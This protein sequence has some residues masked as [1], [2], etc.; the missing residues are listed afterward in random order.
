MNYDFEKFF[1][2]SLDL[3][4]IQ[5]LDGVVLQVNGAF[6]KILGF[7]PDELIGTIPFDRL[8]PEDRE[9][10]LK[11]FRK[12]KDGISNSSIQN[13]YLCA[14][15]TY[16]NFQWTGYPDLET[17]LVYITGRDITE[18]VESNR[19]ISQLAQELKKA[20]DTLFEQACTDSLTGVK[21]RRFFDE[22]LKFILQKTKQQNAFFSVLMIDV[23]HFKNFNDSFGHA[24]GDRVLITVASLLEGTLRDS[25]LLARYGGE[26]F[27]AALPDTSEKESIEIGERLA[28]SVRAHSWKLRPITIS[29]GIATQPYGADHPLLGSDMISNVIDRADVALYRSKQEG[30]DR[31]SHSS[32]IEK[33]FSK[34]KI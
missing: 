34:Y 14:D 2:H 23:D 12:L 7:T 29:V 5:T 13:R 9:T 22:E 26:E 19:K 1:R 11:E 4:S 27:I 25:D 17:G 18:L 33:E 30:R 15:G 3:L 6:E 16:R 10:S 32:R 28:E 31:V 21:N 24:A 20:N 8:H